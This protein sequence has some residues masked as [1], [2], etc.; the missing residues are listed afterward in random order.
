L[1]VLSFFDPLRQLIKNGVREGF[2]Q[3]SSEGLIVFVDGPASHEEHENY[4]WGK[5]GL[6]AIDGWQRDSA[7]ALFDWTKRM[8]GESAGEDG[9]LGAA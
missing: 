1:N 5:A 2:I 9:E 6:N 7:K 4:D 3:P 8:D